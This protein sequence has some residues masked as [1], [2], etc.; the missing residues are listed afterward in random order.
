ML[1]RKSKRFVPPTPDDDQW[2]LYMLV[3]YMVWCYLPFYKRILTTH[4]AR[5]TASV[6]DPSPLSL[7]STLHQCVCVSHWH[8]KRF[9]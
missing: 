8:F 9:V 3:T 4:L 2:S 1:Y 7:I 5:L 6:R